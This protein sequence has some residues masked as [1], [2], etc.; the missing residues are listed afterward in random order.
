MRGMAS[1]HN[2]TVLTRHI[3]ARFSREFT[4][5][6]SWCQNVGF[7]IGDYALP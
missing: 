5:V 3:K 4:D 2:R 6:R 7:G 1:R